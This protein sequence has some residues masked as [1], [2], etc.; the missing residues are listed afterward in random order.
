[1]VEKTKLLLKLIYLTHFYWM[2][3]MIVVY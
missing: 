2:F 3:I 1:M